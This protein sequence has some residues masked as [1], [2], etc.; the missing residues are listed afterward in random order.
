M[1]LHAVD[2]DGDEA[3]E[4]LVEDSNLGP[5]RY[6][7]EYHDKGQIRAVTGL[8]FPGD[9]TAAGECKRS[10]EDLWQ[11]ALSRGEAPVG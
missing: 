1:L 6:T 11:D 10:A 5:S 8:S 3:G 9:Q 2:A 4:R 7:L